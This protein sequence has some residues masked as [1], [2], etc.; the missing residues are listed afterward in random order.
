MEK[1]EFVELL[2]FEKN[3]TADPDEIMEEV[4]GKGQGKTAT[5]NGK[6][7]EDFMK[8]LGL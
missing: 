1:T 3:Q 7:D 4:K 2:P 5:P 8:E 6:A